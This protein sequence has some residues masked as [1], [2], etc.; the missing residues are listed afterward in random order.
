MV[1]KRF[2]SSIG[3]CQVAL[4][5]A[6]FMTLLL[7]VTLAQE[8][9]GRPSTSRIKSREDAP[10]AQ[11]SK[12]P[13]VVIAAD[14][15]YRLAPSDVLEVI[16]E[17]APELSGNYR[18]NRSGT[19]PMK[20][21]GS[22]QVAGKTTEDVMTMVTEGLRGRYLRDPKVYVTV[23]QYNS[24]TF[25][26]QGAIK[27]PGVFVIEGR[28][29]L[30]KLISIAGGMP[31]NHGSTAYIIREKKVDPAKMERARAG[32]PVENDEKRP[33]V[34]AE[35]ADQVGGARP[36][37]PTPASRA[38]E[39]AK[40]GVTAIDGE[41]EYE[42]L[43]ANISGFYRGRFEQNL[44]IQP[45][46]LV[47]I[48]P[49]EVFFVVGEVKSPGQF[50]LREGSSIRQAISLSQGLLFKAASDRAMIFRQDPATGKLSEIPVDIGAIMNGKKDDVLL[51]PN[52][53]VMIP[54]SKMKAFA[55][56]MMMSM[57]VAMAQTAIL[58]I[59]R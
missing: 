56:S 58:G 46:D 23:K 3:S 41:T 48:P 8:G 14:D 37:I 51:A 59:M 40:S 54:N 38:L 5:A 31:E 27:N 28:P 35:E 52:D 53:V 22:I 2:Q 19:L 21:L 36:T 9:G 15:D 29:S 6:L 42:L 4:Q 18:I 39:D 50:T 43:T 7:S 1:L 30:F 11:T 44:I 17:D 45:N 10:T 24:R 32:L 34:E 12:G 25:F 20:Y 47:Y 13:Q 57:G 26:I 55:G 49:S 33:A 16:I